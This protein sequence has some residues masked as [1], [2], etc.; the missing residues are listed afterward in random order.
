MGIN[1]IE[2]ELKNLSYPSSNSRNV[3]NSFENQLNEIA[4][5]E[6]VIIFQDNKSEEEIDEKSFRSQEEQQNEIIP[7]SLP[8]DNKRHSNMFIVTEETNSSTLIKNRKRGRHTNSDEE[9]EKKHDKYS[10]DNILRKIQVNYLSFI[11]LFL[12]DVLSSLGI[13]EKFLNLDY[14]FKKQVNKE[15]C[16]LL[17]KRNIGEIVSEKISSKYKNKD[18]VNIDLYENLKKNANLEKIFNMNYLTF[19]GDYYMIKGKSVNLRKFGIEKEITLSNKTET[20]FDFIA[21]IKSKEKDEKYIRLI[22]DCIQKNY[23]KEISLYNA[24]TFPID[25]NY[26]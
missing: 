11:I 7:A 12:N 18:N 17:K 26:Y 9:K 6:M 16:E 20:Y 23:L 4:V 2:L 1:H 15:K 22:N 8:E 24:E 21:K 10:E 14:E 13:Q 25:V 19:F 3:N 5:P